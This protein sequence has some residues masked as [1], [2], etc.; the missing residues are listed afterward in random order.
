MEDV[1]NTTDGI[2]NT[3]RSHEEILNS[4]TV[5]LQQ[6]MY[7]QDDIKNRNRRNNI[8]IRGIPETVEHKDLAVA[9]T[10]IFN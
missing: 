7:R 1:E 5:M 8:R 6:L 9:V 10:A 2:C 4:H 3:V